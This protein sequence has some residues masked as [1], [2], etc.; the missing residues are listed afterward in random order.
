VIYR[1]AA[2]AARGRFSGAGAIEGSHKF[3]SGYCTPPF[4]VSLREVRGG[5]QVKV[6]DYLVSAPCAVRDADP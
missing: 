5:D 6:P 3:D 4:L 1:L 2:I